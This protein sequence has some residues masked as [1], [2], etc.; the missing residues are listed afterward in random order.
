MSRLSLL[1]VH[2][3]GFDASFWDPL[4]STLG[5]P[6]GAAADLGYFG[7]PF[8]PQ[9]VGPVLVVA[10]SLGAMLALA[11]P[12]PGCVGLVAINGFDRF[13]AGQD[14]PGIQ[15]RVIDR[16]LA[17]LERDPAAAVAD[18][19]TRSGGDT[20]FGSPD[21]RRLA[22]HLLLL[23]DGDERSRSAAWPWPLLALHG[24]RDPI[25]PSSLRSIVF[26]GAPRL[27]RHSHAEGGHVLPLSHPDWCARGL[28]AMLGR[29]TAQDP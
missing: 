10:H 27:E 2:G 22:N 12:P 14:F 11:D 21:A 24:E 6:A 15:R 13:G 29:L 8:A 4:R 17:K 20:A 19:R 9:P 5:D 7:A 18:F 3:W 26:H 28:L 25:L 23:R 1:F 16:M